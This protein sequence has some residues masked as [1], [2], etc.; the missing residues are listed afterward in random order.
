M[1]TSPIFG[2][3]II[4]FAPYPV[5]TVDVNQMSLTVRFAF[6]RERDRLSFDQLLEKNSDQLPWCSSNLLRNL[7]RFLHETSLDTHAE[8]I[9]HATIVQRGT[10]PFKPHRLYLRPN[11]GNGKPAF[12]APDLAEP[13][14]LNQLVPGSSPILPAS[15]R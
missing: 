7:C 15:S 12:V 14:P 10:G 5:S 2:A 3:G 9:S 1:K 4:K 13:L 11:Q 8:N 6:E